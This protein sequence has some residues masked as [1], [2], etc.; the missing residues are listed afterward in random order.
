MKIPAATLKKLRR[1]CDDFIEDESGNGIADYGAILAILMVLG[2]VGAGWVLFSR[3]AEKP[4]GTVT[5]GSSGTCVSTPT[6]Q[7]IGRPHRVRCE[8][9][10]MG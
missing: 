7:S 4:A 6:P 5:A 3:Q 1:D 10:G 9:C 8:A 2:G